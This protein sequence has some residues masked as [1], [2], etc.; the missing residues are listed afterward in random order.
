MILTASNTY[1]RRHDDRAGS[2]Q[3]GNGGTAG[4]LSTSS[5]IIDNGT[6]V[7]NRSN[8]VTQGTDFSG[9]ASAARVLSCKQGRA[10]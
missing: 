1:T 2:L 5:S 7:L 6:L 8:T 3:I 9:L 10:C 4:T